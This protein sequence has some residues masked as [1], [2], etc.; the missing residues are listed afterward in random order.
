MK[1]VQALQYNSRQSFAEIGRNIGLS[2]PA[3]ADRVQ[4]LEE[5]GVIKGYSVV[6]DY[7]QLGFPVRA[8]ITLK[9]ATT[10][11]RN[12]IAR[13]DQF[14]EIL[15]CVKLTG[16]NCASL[17]VVVK[18]NAALEK[19]IDRLTQYGHPNTSII[20]SSYDRPLK[21]ES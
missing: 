13:L 10:D 4:K 12:F 1:I 8:Q 9:T 15:E 20:L 5:T 16:E 17:S 18:S 14:P 7:E 6:L 19:L 11:F 3:V 2:A 21:L